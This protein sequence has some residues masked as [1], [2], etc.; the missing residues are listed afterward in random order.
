MKLQSTIVLIF[1]FFSALAQQPC[2]HQ[3]G[4]GYFYDVELDPSEC[5]EDKKEFYYIWFGGVENGLLHGKGMLMTYDAQT[6]KDIQS[7]ATT[8]VHGYQEG[9]SKSSEKDEE[10]KTETVE[11]SLYEKGRLQRIYKEYDCSYYKITVHHDYNTR[12][13]S[14]LFQ[15]KTGTKV[16][17]LYT[18]TM[19][20]NYKTFDGKFFI[21][22]ILQSS[23][24]FKPTYNSEL[25]ISFPLEYHSACALQKGTCYLA[26]GITV[27]SDDFQDSSCATLRY[28]NGD[29]ITSCSFDG[30]VFVTGYG[31]YYWNDGRKFV[32]KLIQSKITQDGYFY[33]KNGNSKYGSFPKVSKTDDSL[34]G[35][36]VI[37]LAAY[38][39]YQLTQSDTPTSKNTPVENTSPIKEENY[40]SSSSYTGSYATYSDSHSQP[41]KCSKCNGRG[42]CTGCN[43][44][45][46]SICWNCDGKG[47]SGPTMNI[48]GQELD[49]TCTKCDGKGFTKCY[50][51]YGSGSCTQC[52][53]K[54][55]R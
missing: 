41:S 18:G 34:L 29:Y 37:G 33:D 16:K 3:A 25:D 24:I 12:A 21:D 53:G 51:C 28:T 23:G 46:T 17:I 19:S 30:S 47:V 35:L 7:E 44:R 4:K 5:E 39:I 15:G 48:I 20:P 50:T 45:G 32:G 42:V 9:W 43:G 26:N 31:T 1:I 11:Y 8:F 22:D 27:T 13:F 54:G 36:A 40:T 49:N 2:K 38:G 10:N 55:T 14:H 6:K 52:Q